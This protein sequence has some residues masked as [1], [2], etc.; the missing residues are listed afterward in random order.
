MAED[1]RNCLISTE[2]RKISDKSLNR[3]ICSSKSNV[4]TRKVFRNSGQSFSSHLE[5]KLLEKSSNI[6][7][8]NGKN[9]VPRIPAKYISQGSLLESKKHSKMLDAK[10]KMDILV[11]SLTLQGLYKE[12]FLLN[13][14]NPIPYAE[15]VCRFFDEMVNAL[16]LIAKGESKNAQFF[17]SNSKIRI[18]SDVWQMDIVIA[19]SGKIQDIKIL[20]SNRDFFDKC[21]KTM[22]KFK[23]TM[24]EYDWLDEIN[25]TISF[26]AKTKLEE[27]ETLRYKVP[28][29][30]NQGTDLTEFFIEK[31]VEKPNQ[32]NLI[33]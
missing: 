29:S 5:K 31:C 28:E 12:C 23:Q 24:S 15:E 9:L 20:T 8:T 11:L 26:E 16:N 18:L 4:D 10:S 32:L 2:I 21:S 17:V 7:P 14:S 25:F 27:S 33:I 22:S 13:T 6:K 30:F 19:S 1:T 3:G